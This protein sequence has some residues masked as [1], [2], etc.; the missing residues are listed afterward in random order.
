MQT[1][2]FK[3]GDTIVREGD[4]GHTGFLITTGSVELSLAKP[5]G[6]WAPWR[7]ERCSAKCV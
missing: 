1:V 6:F 2:T 5:G 7:R 4:E 3:A